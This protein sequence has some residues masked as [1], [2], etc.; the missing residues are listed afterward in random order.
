MAVGGWWLIF[1]GWWLIFSGWWL[2]FGVLWLVVDIWRL[3]VGGWWLVVGFLFPVSVAVSV[4]VSVSVQQDE[5][6]QDKASQGRVWVHPPSPPPPYHTLHV[7]FLQVDVQYK[8]AEGGEE[9]VQHHRATRPRHPTATTIPIL[10]HQPKHLK[11][12]FKDICDDTIDKQCEYW[13]KSFVKEFEGRVPEILELAEEFKAYLPDEADVCA[14]S[15]S[16]T[17]R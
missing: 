12:Q 2:I 15:T 5:T 16:S 4:S 11:K 10:T 17:R 3:A 6:R 14:T 1:G 7:V 9:E 13:L 8:T